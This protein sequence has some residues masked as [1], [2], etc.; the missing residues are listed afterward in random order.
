MG[1]PRVRRWHPAGTGGG[2]RALRMTHAYAGVPCGH[3]QRTDREGPEPTSDDFLSHGGE[4]TGA[5]KAAYP[6]LRLTP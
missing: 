3:P 5:A 6:S 2:Q 4:G 1:A